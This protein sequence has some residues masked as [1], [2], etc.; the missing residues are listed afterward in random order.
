MGENVAI[1]DIL[2]L[3]WDNFSELDM[4]L[5]F[6][7]LILFYAIFIKY[8]KGITVDLIKVIGKK[9][10]SNYQYIASF[11]DN[12]KMVKIAF[13]LFPL[14]FVNY[15]V[16]Y[17]DNETQNNT[18]FNLFTHGLYVFNYAFTTYWLSNFLKHT[19]NYLNNNEKYKNKPLLSF[20]QIVFIIF[21]I[22]VLVT[23]YAHFT[24]QSPKTLFTTL[25]VMSMAVFWTL[26]DVIMG[27]VSTILIVTNDIVK[28]GDWIKNEKYDAD[29]N[30]IEINLITVKILNFDKTI[31]TIPTYALISE[32]F[33][34]Q[35]E[36][37]KNGKRLIKHSVRIDAASIRYLTAEEVEKYKEVDLIRSHIEKRLQQIDKNTIKQNEVDPAKQAETA[38]AK[39]VEIKTESDSETEIITN[40]TQSKLTDGD[41]YHKL[42]NL[43]Q[44]QFTNLGLFRKYVEKMVENNGMVFNEKNKKA[45]ENGENIVIRILEGTREG[46][47]LE[48]YCFSKK[49]EWG[50]YNYLIAQLSE[51]IY[52]SAKYFDLVINS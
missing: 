12:Q 21:S 2:K 23:I 36:I 27:I 39:Q 49:T 6:G 14:L 18:S 34:N 1:L 24:K 43:N 26:K 47:G 42:S 44:L 35:Q 7:I 8:F 10:F 25:S 52:A 9:L 41:V 19:V 17:D 22:I 31:S 50:E 5:K 45:K 30:I 13:Y 29:G 28:V 40:P 4:V 51:E 3:I 33:Q 48:L 20:S 32:G 37:L 16:F 11:L 15:F 46:V 38:Q